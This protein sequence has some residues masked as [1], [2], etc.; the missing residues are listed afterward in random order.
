MN[1]TIQHADSNHI[2]LLNEI[3]LAAA[4]IFPPGSIPEY[5]FTDKLPL[6]DL[7]AAM[8]RDML[9]VVLD[10]EKTPVGYALLQLIDGCALLAQMDVHPEHGQKGVGTALLRRVIEEVGDMGLDAVYL[11]TFSHIKW[12]APFY[13]KHGFRIL[14]PPEQPLF[15]QGILQQERANG[16][17]NRVAMRFPILGKGAASNLGR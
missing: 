16:L 3:E 5:V 15:L 6:D 7:H 11:T 13:E 14:E 9:W 1:Y 4:T 10:G 17:P 12:N 8:D 2:P